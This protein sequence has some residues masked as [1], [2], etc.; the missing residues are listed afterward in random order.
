MAVGAQDVSLF[1]AGAHT[2]EASA[3]AVKDAGADWAIVG[4]SERRE[5]RGVDT[6]RGLQ[7]L[8]VALRLTGAL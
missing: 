4:H 3:A 8:A 2:G 1:G 5:V 6:A 7:G